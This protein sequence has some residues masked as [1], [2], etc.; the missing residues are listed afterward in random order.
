M[1]K[2]FNRQNLFQISCFDL[3][4]R[5]HFLVLLS[6]VGLRNLCELDWNLR[7]LYPQIP[8]NLFL[9]SYILAF[10]VQKIT[11]KQRLTT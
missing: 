11:S 9:Y 5:F 6:F 4:E 1:A 3:R 2:R 7:I 8:F 10:Y